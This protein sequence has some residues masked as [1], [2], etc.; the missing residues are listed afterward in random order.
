MWVSVSDKDGRS[1]GRRETL[2][3]FSF[4]AFAGVG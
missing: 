1:F 2:W 3:S 4:D